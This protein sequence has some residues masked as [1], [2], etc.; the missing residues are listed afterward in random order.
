MW[1]ISEVSLKFQGLILRAIDLTVLQIFISDQLV[2]LQD[3]DRINFLCSWKWAK[4]KVG[5][6]VSKAEPDLIFDLKSQWQTNVR[7][8][9]GL[10]PT[11]SLPRMSLRQKP[12]RI[13]RLK[14]GS[15]DIPN[16]TDEFFR[17]AFNGDNYLD[18]LSLS[19]LKNHE[20]VTQ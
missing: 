6:P 8:G 17:F 3:D 11:L 2:E 14:H 5:E 12:C 9:R 15:G 7:A 13:S 19:P 16:P 20:D 1:A 18:L 4:D 10:W